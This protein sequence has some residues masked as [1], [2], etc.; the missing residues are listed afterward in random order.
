MERK[1]DRLYKNLFS[2]G[3][4]LVCV[5]LLLSVLRT[6]PAGAQ[7]SLDSSTV[8]LLDTRITTFF[9]ALQQEGA[10]ASTSVFTDFLGQS[11]LG[12]DESQVTTLRRDVNALIGQ[13]GDILHWERYDTRQIGT[14]TIVIRYVLLYDQYPV[15]WSFAFY[16]KPSLTPGINPNPWTLVGLQF[17]PNL[18]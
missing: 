13:F 1:H 9:R 15:I 3:V 12:S 11:P 8:Q 10:T 6:V 5:L 17:D 7:S 2:I 4:A 14:N 16:R 18:L